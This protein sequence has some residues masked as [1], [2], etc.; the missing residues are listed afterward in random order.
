[1]FS[2]LVEKSK[3]ALDTNTKTIAKL[4]KH[5][6]AQK[7]K[8]Q[9]SETKTQSNPTGIFSS[10]SREYNN[11]YCEAVQFWSQDIAQQFL[12]ATQQVALKMA[13]NGEEGISLLLYSIELYVISSCSNQRAIVPKA[14]VR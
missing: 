6:I 1:M 2:S 9:R 14:Y 5:S 11:L 12:N 7:S 13:L 3:A 8:T 10:E 4:M